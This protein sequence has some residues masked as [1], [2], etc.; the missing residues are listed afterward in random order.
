MTT[1][2]KIK[3]NAKIPPLTILETIKVPISVRQR[4]LIKLIDEEDFDMVKRKVR[5]EFQEYGIETNENYLNEGI[6][7]LKQYYAICFMDDNPHAISDKLDPFWHAH[8][9][10]TIDY[11]QFCEK[12]DIDYMHHVPNNP[13]DREESKKLRI[14]YDHTQQVYESC[15]NWISPIFNDVNLLTE[16]LVCTHYTQSRFIKK[17]DFAFK[18]QQYLCDLQQSIKPFLN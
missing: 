2:F 11:H 4:N 10:H 5:H 12:L 3:V 8:I 9:L 7:A 1:T 15:F 18:R 16:N 13:N 14:I 17:G 6:L